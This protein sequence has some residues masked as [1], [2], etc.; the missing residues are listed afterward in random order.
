MKVSNGKPDYSPLDDITPYMDKPV[1]FKHVKSTGMNEV[2][3]FSN[4]ERRRYYYAPDGS[5]YPSVTTVLHH[6][7]PVKD[8]L[9]KWRERVGNSVADHIMQQSSKTGSL[10]HA[11]IERYLNNTKI[12]MPQ[13]LMAYGHLKNLEPYLFYIDNIKATEAPL[14]DTTLGCAGTVDCIADFDGTLSIIDFKTM[15]SLKENDW[16]HDYYVQA[17]AY[18]I[19]W[20]AMTGEHIDQSVILCTAEDGKSKAVLKD[21]KSYE[22]EFRERLGRYRAEIGDY[23]DDANR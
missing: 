18:G 7:A 22:H 6:T 15:R 9:K 11:L 10:T 21:N 2:D 12:N 4:S 3:K 13:P 8:G 1:K 19:M 20:H 14:V 5:H 16:M 17:A 23:D